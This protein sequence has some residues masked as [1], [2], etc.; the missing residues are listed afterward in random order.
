MKA[1]SAFLLHQIK[2]Q[3]HLKSCFKLHIVILDLCL[4]VSL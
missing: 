4:G 1:Q 3:Y 2:G